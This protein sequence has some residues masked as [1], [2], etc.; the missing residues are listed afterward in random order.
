MD[1][2]VQN[3]QFK[4]WICHIPASVVWST[5]F[6]SLFLIMGQEILNEGLRN[7]RPWGRFLGCCSE[8]E[9]TISSLW[10][11]LFRLGLLTCRVGTLIIPPCCPVRI[12]RDCRWKSAFQF[13]TLAS[14]IW[15]RTR[16]LSWVGGRPIQ[17]LDVRLRCLLQPPQARA[18]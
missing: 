9:G 6:I 4:I 11:L 15:D 18:S 10:S 1:F 13:V 14:S 12:K 3:L 5:Y 8:W 7:T 17:D 2:S 16:G